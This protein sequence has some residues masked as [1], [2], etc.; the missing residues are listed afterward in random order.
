MIA[1]AAFQEARTLPV[2]VGTAAATSSS[3]LMAD[4][5]AGAVIV[6]GV[7]SEHSLT[8]YGSTD[9]TTF[10][11]LYGHDGQAATMP[12]PAGG[13]ECVMPDAVHPLRYIRL[14]A[15]SDLGTA[16]SVRVSLR[17]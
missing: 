16:V 7:T 8:V 2:A 17:G 14:V 4:I 3:M 13:G 6:E 12:V 1:R 15:D 9:G 11:P 10:V 5:A